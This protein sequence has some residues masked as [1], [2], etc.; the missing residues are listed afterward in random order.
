VG[1]FAVKGDVVTPAGV[2]PRLDHHRRR[3]DRLD[4]TKCRSWPNVALYQTLVKAPQNA[5]TAAGLKCQAVKHGEVRQNVMGIVGFGRSVS[6]T[7]GRHGD[8]QSA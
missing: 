6:G 7:A 5:V 3:E 8:H 2:L 4:A 1:R